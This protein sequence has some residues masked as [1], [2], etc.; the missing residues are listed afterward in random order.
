LSYNLIKSVGFWDKVPEAIAEDIHNFSKIYWHR[1]GDAY[2]VPIYTPFNGL[3]LDCGDNYVENC[4]GKF[5]QAVRHGNAIF[6]C[7]YNI[8]EFARQKT[9]TLKSYLFLWYYL[10]MVLYNTTFS[11]FIFTYQVIRSQFIEY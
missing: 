4:K 11:T 3:N 8:Y 7:S 5:W 9:K 2:S 6:E 10:D 1:K